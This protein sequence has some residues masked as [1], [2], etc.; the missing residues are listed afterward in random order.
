MTGYI[1]DNMKTTINRNLVIMLAT[2]FLGTVLCDR[3][4]ASI[5]DWSSQTTCLDI[6]AK[7]PDG[8]AKNRKVA[9]LKRFPK[10]K[11][12]AAIYNA[13]A[14]LDSNEPN[15]IICDRKESFQGYSTGIQL[16]F[17]SQQ[18][19]LVLGMSCDFRIPEIKYGTKVGYAYLKFNVKCSQLITN[20]N[21]FYT[22]DADGWYPTMFLVYDEPI[23]DLDDQTTR[24]A[25]DEIYTTPDLYRT[26][27]PRSEYSRK[28]DTEARIDGTR[29]EIENLYLKIRNGLEPRFYISFFLGKPSGCF[30]S[31]RPR[32]REAVQIT[33]N[34]G[35]DYFDEQSET[36]IRAWDL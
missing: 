1:W 29:A 3:A 25:G 31:A 20:L 30:A 12:N 27:K 32:S 15:G 23:T 8:V 4:S 5:S 36:Y 28:Y 26:I 33:D 13:N 21:S 34:A 7:Y 16:K 6:R 35:C 22:F 17:V 18:L 24:K 19:E 2:V 14:N 11:I 9:G 10:A